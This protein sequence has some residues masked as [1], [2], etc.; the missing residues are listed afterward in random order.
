[1]RRGVVV[2]VR[3][4]TGSADDCARWHLGGGVQ[5]VK[6]LAVAVLLVL[7]ARAAAQFPD[8]FFEP[9]D[10]LSWPEWTWVGMDE[11]WLLLEEPDP[12]AKLSDWWANPGPGFG[13]IAALDPEYTWVMYGLWLNAHGTYAAARNARDALYTQQTMVYQLHALYEQG[14][15]SVEVLELIHAM[16]VA[17]NA[18]LVS[19]DSRVGTMNT[20]MTQMNTRIAT[21]SAN[22]TTMVGHLEDMVASLAVLE[23]FFED[24]KEFSDMD[25]IPPPVLTPEDEVD[26][27]EIP[28]PE[29][30]EFAIDVPWYSTAATGTP[31]WNPWGESAFPHGGTWSP[32]PPNP[33]V[34]WTIP[35][36]EFGDFTADDL[37]LT[38]DFSWFVTEWRNVFWIVGTVGVGMWGMKF[39]LHWIRKQ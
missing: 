22:T 21:M 33:T 11:D 38:P 20:T 2:R 17:N 23:L 39:L 29:V 30:P 3:L 18:R 26:A 10:P 16:E 25:E 27:G 36:A 37:F 1:M 28:M 4:A 31:G 13:S 8:P 12:H 9:G 7:A 24:F 35:G 19:I 34:T 5:G 6:V 15:D 32:T 14:D